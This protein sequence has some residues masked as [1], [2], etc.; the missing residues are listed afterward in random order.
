MGFGENAMDK[1]RET[2]D[3]WTLNGRQLDIVEEYMYLGI[4]FTPTLNTKK[5]I[6]DRKEKGLKTFGSMTHIISCKTIPIPIRL[7][8][9]KSALIPV[10]SY[11]GELWSIAGD[12]AVKP[13]QAILN[14]SLKLIL[15]HSAKNNLPAMG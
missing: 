4:P 8:M 9:V 2:P 13:L 12:C 7:S 11:A 1:L 6:Q 10:L 5:M 14:S 3:G 15:G